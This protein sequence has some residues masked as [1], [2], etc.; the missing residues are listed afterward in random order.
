VEGGTTTKRETE[1]KNGFVVF[2]LVFPLRS[3]P[4][5]YMELWYRTGRLRMAQSRDK[6][7]KK[8]VRETETEKLT[9][10]K[11]GKKGEDPRGEGLRRR[12]VTMSLTRRAR[13][14]RMI[15]R[16]KGRRMEGEGEK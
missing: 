3:G 9:Q 13:A 11:G 15:G 6:K 16:E 1:S 14:N 4:V 8:E 5:V 12:G 7:K 2:P 10:R